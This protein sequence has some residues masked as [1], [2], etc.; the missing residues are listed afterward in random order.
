MGKGSDPSCTFRSQTKMCRALV[1]CRCLTRAILRCM[2]IERIQ[3]LLE[4][5]A[6]FLGEAREARVLT[7][8][9]GTLHQLRGGLP[10]RFGVLGTR[11]RSGSCLLLASCLGERDRLVELVQRLRGAVLPQLT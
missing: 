6:V 8:R 10:D 4:R 11:Q 5:G 9:S 1:L 3:D 2:S 7:D